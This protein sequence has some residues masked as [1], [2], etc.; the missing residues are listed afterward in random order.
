MIRLNIHATDPKAGQW[1]DD[2]VKKIL[3]ESDLGSKPRDM[4]DISQ[5]R[6]LLRVLIHAALPD[7]PSPATTRNSKKIINILDDDDATKWNF[8]P[9][10]GEL[11]LRCSSVVTYNTTTYQRTVTI[12]NTSTKRAHKWMLQ[13][14][15]HEY[16][17]P[18]VG[19]GML[20][21]VSLIFFFFNSIL[22]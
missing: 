12:Q 7:I 16:F 15:P 21:P 3:K 8:V 1:S 11:S 2:V 6:S 18:N 5:E 20:A 19:F 4:E 13:V 10:R 22:C 17:V 14:H 9:P